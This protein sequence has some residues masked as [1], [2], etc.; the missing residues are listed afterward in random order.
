MTLHHTT[1]TP[2]NIFDTA[3][4]LCLLDLVLVVFCLDGKESEESYWYVQASFPTGHFSV[5]IYFFLCLT[6]LGPDFR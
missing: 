4:S 6:G 2:P 3:L 5:A 1:A